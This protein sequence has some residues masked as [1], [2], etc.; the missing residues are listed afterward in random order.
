MAVDQ[1]RM[2][3]G[4]RGAVDELAQHAVIGLVEPLDPPQRL[5]DGRRPAIDLLPVGDDPRDGAEPA[6][7]PHRAVLAKGGSRPSNMRGSSS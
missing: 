7:D 4:A 3:E 2:A 5:V 1:D 6:G